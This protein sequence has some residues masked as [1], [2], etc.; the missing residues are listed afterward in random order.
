MYVEL[1][2]IRNENITEDELDDDRAEALSQGWQQWFERK[3]GLWFEPRTMTL[4]FDGDGSRILHFNFPIITVTSLYIN[5][6][7][8]NVVDTDDYVV[9]NRYFPEDD[10]KNPRIK[11]KHSTDTS[12]PFVSTNGGYFLKGDQNQ[13]V[14][15]TFGFVEEDGTV[16]FAVFRAILTLVVLSASYMA[17]GDIDIL[18]SGLVTEEVTDRHR[19]RYDSLYKEIGAW[20][21]TGIADV[22]DAIRSYR[23][24]MKIRS[25]R[26]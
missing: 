10:R 6:D 24:P 16:P 2:D 9:Y 11:L 5:D 26:R 13:K 21:P 7:F 4:L 3:T 14:I 19:V 18:R 23:R 17:D 22:D 1:T 25:P 8:D 15:G 20:N 12:F